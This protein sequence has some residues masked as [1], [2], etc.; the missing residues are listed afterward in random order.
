MLLDFFSETIQGGEIK[1]GAGRIDIGLQQHQTERAVKHA[2][3]KGPLGTCDLVLVKLHGIDLAAAVCVVPG[4]RPEHTAQQN[5]CLSAKGMNR[6]CCRCHDK[7][8][9]RIERIFFA[10]E[11]IWLI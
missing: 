11:F 1:E 3:R 10:V 4:V 9:S 8:P 2:Q 7:A 6:W 5:F